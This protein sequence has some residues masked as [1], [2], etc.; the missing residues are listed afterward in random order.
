MSRLLLNTKKQWC[1]ADIGGGR[2]KT[3]A[4]LTERFYWVGMINDVREYSRTCDRCQRANR[5]VATLFRMCMVLRFSILL[6]GTLPCT[7][8]QEMDLF[9]DTLTP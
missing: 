8:M 2:D 1:H 5:F 3:F 6:A 7:C 9:S 4:K